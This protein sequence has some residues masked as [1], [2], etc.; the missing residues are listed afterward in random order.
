ML[1][2]TSTIDTIM[3]LAELPNTLSPVGDLHADGPW[4]GLPCESLID[5]D[6]GRLMRQIAHQA[7]M[8]CFCDVT[9]FQTNPGTHRPKPGCPLCACASLFSDHT[10]NESPSITV[11]P[12]WVSP[13]WGVLLGDQ[14]WAAANC[15]KH[16]WTN[17][18]QKAAHTGQSSG[19]L[20]TPKPR[21][22][23]RKAAVTG[24]RTLS[25]VTPDK[26][27]RQ[28]R[29]QLPQRSTAICV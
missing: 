26:K 5:W 23:R 13:L 9:P 29:I 27:R 24:N 21:S 18:L 14:N 1:V 3:K 28:I 16:R 15:Q 6:K 22:R 12:I 11:G 20:Q 10:W 2:R 25:S 19:Y 17:T 4:T 7:A 8:T